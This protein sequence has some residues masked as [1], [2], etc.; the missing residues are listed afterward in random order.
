MA[1]IDSSSMAAMIV[2]EADERR[3]RV[4]I[5]QVMDSSVRFDHVM[6]SS[7]VMCS[8]MSYIINFVLCFSENDFQWTWDLGV[9]ACL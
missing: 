3:R 7:L 9:R 6:D 5:T 8:I 4:W 2:M 1:V